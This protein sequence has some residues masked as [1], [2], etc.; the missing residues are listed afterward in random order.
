MTKKE[1]ED[2]L[3]HCD[4][5]DCQCFASGEIDCCCEVDWNPEDYY[6]LQYNYDLYKEAIKNI[7]N[8]VP[9]SDDINYL[10]K[11]TVKK[12]IK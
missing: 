12:E 1:L 6:K 11:D 9:I 3:E 8:I 2:K 4:G 10:I 7:Q 5:K